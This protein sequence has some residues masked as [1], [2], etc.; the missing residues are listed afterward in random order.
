MKS[1]LLTKNLN[2]VFLKVTFF[3]FKGLVGSTSYFC[4]IVFPSWEHLTQTKHFT[5]GKLLPCA[6][7]FF[8]CC[9]T[10]RGGRKRNINI[11]KNV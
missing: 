6:H 2:R 3:F 9:I 1:S 7:S 10:E 11:I 8:C 4:C 5:D